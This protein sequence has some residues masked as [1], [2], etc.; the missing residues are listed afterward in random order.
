MTLEVRQRPLWLMSVD[1]SATD[2]PKRLELQN[3]LLQSQITVH[4]VY[5]DIRH[6]LSDSPFW[7]PKSV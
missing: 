6:L 4:Q 3:Y 7:S 5:M 2:H 1:I